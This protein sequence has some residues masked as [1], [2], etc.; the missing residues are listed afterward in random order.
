[1]TMLRYSRLGDVVIRELC[2]VKEGESVLVVADTGTDRGIADAYLGAAINAGARALL[3]VE[4]ERVLTDL[5][6]APSLAGAIREAD[7]ILGICA[8]VFSRS[9]ACVAARER[10][11]RILL[12]DPR[13]MEQYLIDGI[14]NIDNQAMA[15]N[16][17]VLTG[18]MEAADRCEITSA[19]GTS[20][21]CRLGDRPILVSDGRALDPGEMDYYP[22]AQVSV[23]AIEESIDGVIV[24]DGSMSTLGLVT[25]PFGIRIEQGRV[26]GFEGEGS[27]VKRWE[28][29]IAEQNDPKLAQCCHISFGLNPRASV[30]GNIYEDERYFGCVDFGFGSQD[31]SF[32]GTIG[33]S[34]HHVDVVLMSPK[35]VLDGQVVLEE[36]RLNAK[37]GFVGA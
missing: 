21:T 2:D 15:R 20:L 32:G 27:D 6:I 10:G 30:S 35:L 11:A 29:H 13:G 36:N 5:E 28:K 34:N 16:T 26:T 9:E 23:A 3:A 22:G 19:N 14:V 8:G 1:M 18:L 7:V 4:R 33:T 31:P 24:V 25:Q 12:T 17:E 37:L